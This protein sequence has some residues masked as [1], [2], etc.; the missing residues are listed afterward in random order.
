MAAAGAG[1]PAVARASRRVGLATAAVIA[2]IYIAVALTVHIPKDAPTFSD[3][4]TYA[5]M[6]DSLAHDGDLA[7]RAEDLRRV[8]AITPPGPGGG[9]QG[10]FLK[11]GVDVTGVA[12]APSPPFFR[13]EGQPDPDTTRLFFGKAFIY[14]LFAAPFVLAFGLNGFLWLNALLLAVA[15]LT[16]YIFVGARSGTLVSLLLAGAFVFATVVPVYYAW[17]MPELFNFTLGLVA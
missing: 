9:P 6:A 11:P 7:Y 12:L 2:A 4:W 1:T 16:A 3:E 8:I 10:L 14:P 13:I 5:M 17:M 15:F